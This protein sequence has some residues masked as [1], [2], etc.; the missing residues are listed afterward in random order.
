MDVKTKLDNDKKGLSLA[1]IEKSLVC[2]MLKIEMM[3]DSERI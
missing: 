2:N 3:N 1:T